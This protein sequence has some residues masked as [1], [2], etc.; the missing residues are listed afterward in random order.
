MK[1]FRAKLRAGFTIIELMIAMAIFS[2]IAVTIYSGSSKSFELRESLSLDGDFYSSIRVALDT[3]GRDI[4]QI[5]SPQA[6]SLPGDI[7]KSP[8][9]QIVPGGAPPVILSPNIYKYWGAL[10]NEFGVRPSRFIGEEKKVSFIS[11]S[12]SRLYKD[13][14][15]TE[16][17][18]I[19]YALEDDKLSKKSDLALIKYEDPDAFNLDKDESEQMIRYSLLNGIKSIK[20]RYLDGEKDQW[21]SS[22][23]NT[24]MNNKDKFP[25]IIEIEL[26]ASMPKTGNSFTVIQHYRP[27]LPL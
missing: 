1:T 27:E 26:E 14:A 2:F 23:D 6:A 15:E 24:S 3:L 4:I 7:G 9:T 22:W 21:Y 13:S 5:Y 10:I 17:A 8:P 12:H 16:F 11:N 20:F 25:S 18:K 19:T